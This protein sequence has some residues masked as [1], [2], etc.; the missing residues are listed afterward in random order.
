MAL[1]NRADLFAQVIVMADQKILVFVVFLKVDEE[2]DIPAQAADPF[3]I[4]VAL[5]RPTPNRSK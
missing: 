3:V 5:C 2:C 4:E 1:S